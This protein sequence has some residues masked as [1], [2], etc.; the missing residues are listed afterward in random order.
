MDGVGM[1][2]IFYFLSF[3]FFFSFCIFC[4][5]FFFALKSRVREVSQSTSRTSSQHRKTEEAGSVSREFSRRSIHRSRSRSQGRWRERR[6]SRERRHRHSPSRR[7]SNRLITCKPRR[8]C[9]LPLEWWD[10]TEDCKDAKSLHMEK[11]DRAFDG[12]RVRLVLL[13]TLWQKEVALE[14]NM[15]P[16]K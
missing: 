1:V 7:S 6:E 13:T 15:F 11:V 9:D 5:S 12:D 2:M 16:C 10:R 4:I 8:C 3:F 14:P